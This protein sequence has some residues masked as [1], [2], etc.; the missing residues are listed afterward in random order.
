MAITVS[1]F[2]V[3]DITCGGSNTPSYG[4][5]STT[6]KEVRTGYYNSTYKYVTQFRF[7]FDKP[8]SSF[9]FQLYSYAENGSTGYG[10][11]YWKVSTEAEDETLAKGSA[12]DGAP[13]DVAVKHTA[14]HQ[15]KT[16]T[17]TG[18][19]AADTD[20]Y[21]YGFRYGTSYNCCSFYAF[22]S[23]SY[24]SKIT[25]AVELDGV[26]YIDNGTSFDAY[27]IYIDNGTSW[28][29]YMA[30]IDNGSSWDTCG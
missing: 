20:Y 15:I 2:A 30:C 24:C 19:F 12:V 8:C 9:T 10:T 18:P 16:V 3:R 28:D 6:K 7:R 21:L 4:E 14:A 27:E 17:F 5:W 23:S 13:Y 25:E 1:N 29:Q 26:I 22:Y 11:S